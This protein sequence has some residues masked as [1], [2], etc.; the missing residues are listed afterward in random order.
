MISQ[1]AKVESQGDQPRQ[2]ASYSDRHPTQRE[3]PGSARCGPAELKGL[4][5]A[6]LFLGSQ[7]GWLQASVIFHTGHSPHDAILIFRQQLYNSSSTQTVQFWHLPGGCN[8]RHQGTVR[9]CLISPTHCSCTNHKESAML[10]WFNAH[11]LTIPAVQARVQCW[12]V[13][14]LPGVRRGLHLH[15]ICSILKKYNYLF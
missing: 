14:G 2:L 13:L 7:D 9:E 5:L 8:P 6:L 15:T 4:S 1:P 10:S 12:L 3:L 11:W